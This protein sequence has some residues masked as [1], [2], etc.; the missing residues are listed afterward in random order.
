MISIK[1]DQNFPNIEVHIR[2]LIH[3]DHIQGLDHDL[4]V[5]EMAEQNVGSPNLD[6]RV[7]PQY[8]VK[9]Y[10]IDISVSQGLGLLP[11][12]R[13]NM[14][15]TIIPDLRNR[16]LPLK[17][18]KITSDQDLALNHIPDQKEISQDLDLRL[19]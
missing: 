17:N 14:H 11:L 15:E 18:V 8:T 7:K 13:S 2:G 1:V 9:Y 10:P 19:L 3:K 16:H 5:E 4:H 12:I 6:P